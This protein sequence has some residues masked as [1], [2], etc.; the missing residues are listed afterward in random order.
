MDNNDQWEE[1]WD[2]EKKCVYDINKITGEKRYHDEGDEDFVDS[3]DEVY[4][5]SQANNTL[6]ILPEGWEARKDEA[7]GAT[8][9]FNLHTGEATWDAPQNRQSSSHVNPKNPWEE[10][11]DEASG[12]VYY[13]NAKT[14]VAQ[15]ERPSNM[16]LLGR[17]EG[18]N[19]GASIIPSPSSNVNDT[20]VDTNDPDAAI[21]WETKTDDAS[22][23]QYY[24]NGQ[25]GESSWEAPPALLLVGSSGTPSIP[26][27]LDPPGRDGIFQYFG[28][29]LT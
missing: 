8:F 10:R 23:A 16:D 4:T 7:S 25:T 22:G 28:S 17:E 5:T 13:F 15:W 20:N 27:A 11:L 26:D 12:V 19:G 21:N 14:G 24:F 18:V 1:Y 6:Q 3:D 9:Y 2:S 29:N